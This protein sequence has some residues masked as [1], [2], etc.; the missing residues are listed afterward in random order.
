MWT[1]FKVL[2]EFV[3][4]TSWL[5]ELMLL[6]CGVGEDSWQ[7]LDCK[8]MKPVNPKGNQPWNTHRKDRCLKLQYFG[9]LIW[10]ADSLEKTLMLREIEGRRRR[11]Q[12][13]MRWLDGITDSM[14]MSLSKLLELV[15]DREAWHA[16]VRG[17]EKSQAW[18][19]DWTELNCHLVSPK[20]LSLSTW[21]ADVNICILWTKQLCCYYQNMFICLML[22]L[23]ICCLVAQSCP[24]L[25]NPM[26]CSLP[27]FSVHGIFQAR[28]LEWVAISFSMGSSRP[29]DWP[30]SPALWADT[31]L[32][33]SGK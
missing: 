7:S 19:S 4:I 8:E 11:G 31:R 22:Y 2:I 29:R 32:S 20:V 6:N 24:T 5:L 3:T 17:V 15:M 13:R 1:I 25:C 10:R 28:V 9:H 14:D 12:Q 27:G 23:S 21:S 16:A 33:H 26:D 18:L 30:R